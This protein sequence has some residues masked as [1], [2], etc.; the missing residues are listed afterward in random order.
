MAANGLMRYLL[1]ACFPL[2]SFQMF[3]ALGVD[4]AASLL[5]FVCVALLPIPFAL[6]KFGPVIRAKSNYAPAS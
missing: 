2:W 3:E 4:W 1:G 6:Y 5:G